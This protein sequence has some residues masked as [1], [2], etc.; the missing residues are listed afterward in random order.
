[1]KKHYEVNI[2]L[3]VVADNRDDAK[4]EV[5]KVNDLDACDMV[6]SRAKTVGSLWANAIPF[7]NDD[8][9]TC[10]EYL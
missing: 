9:R 5:K 8:D 10:K 1:M 3:Y 7:G 2:R 6:V 4:D